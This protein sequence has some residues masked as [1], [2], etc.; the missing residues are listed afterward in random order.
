[1]AVKEITT[2]TRPN[3]DVS[4]WPPIGKNPV[5]DPLGGTTTFSD[6]GLSFDHVAIINSKTQYQSFL[7]SRETFDPILADYI[8][9]HRTP[10]RTANN[11][12]ASTVFIDMET[13]EEIMVD[14]IMDRL[15]D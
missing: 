8:A 10:Y 6:D 4:W 5:E 9:N 14:E 2:V 12:I 3:V 7:N 13:G 1:M 15:P 11:I